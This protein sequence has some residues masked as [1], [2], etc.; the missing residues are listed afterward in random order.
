[1]A[2]YT[3]IETLK[4]LLAD[5]ALATKNT[6][7]D[8]TLLALYQ[9]RVDGL[10]PD[11]V[12]WYGAPDVVTSGSDAPTG[13]L[14][15]D[16]M[17]SRLALDIDGFEFT[18]SRFRDG[19]QTTPRKVRR[20][21]PG[22]ALFATPSDRVR[23]VLADPTDGVLLLDQNM[24]IVRTFPGL[25]PELTPITGAF[26]KDAEAACPATL[27]ATPTE[28]MIIACGEQHCVQILNYATGGLV[29]TIGTPGMAGFPDDVPVRLTDP[30]SISV[31]ELNSRLFIACRTGN[32]DTDTS[33]A[34]FVCEFDVTAPGAP[35]FVGYVVQGKGLYR[36]N[37][38]ECRRPSDVFFVP[39][40]VSPAVPARL[41]IANGLGD[42]A[43]LERAT[44]TDPWVPTLVIEAQGS[45]YV[46]G[47]D[48]VTVT[49]GFYAENALDVLTG[50]DT[51]TRV[52][53]AV[54]RLGL[55]EVFRAGSTS[56]ATPFG[57]HE[58]TYGVRRIENSMP[59]GT[60][61]R[62]HSTP[63]EPPLTFGVFTQATGVVADETTLP[64]EEVATSVLIVS[65]ADAGR[66][67]RVR[68]SIYST[69]NTVTFNPVTSGVAVQ[70][71]GWFLPPSA[72]F[73]P[74]F[75]TLEV[76]DPGSTTPVVA[77]GPW[78][79]V[80]RAGF[81]LPTQGPAM[82]RYQFRLRASLPR[83]APVRAYELGAVGVILRQ[84][85]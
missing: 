36:L 66:L 15:P 26:Y 33:D 32:P 46:L 43:A 25:V 56:T 37:N 53:V 64:G 65:D 52:S 67:Q 40:V 41:W 12:N 5:P 62:V 58:A 9:A 16:V 34:G 48:V 31:D 3:F 76:R 24:E 22:D 18:L 82:T 70:V 30:V 20:R 55:V 21:R 54:N 11:V 14:A 69:T 63:L 13:S 81:S 23:Y 7:L 2:V 50:S 57:K 60:P 28:H 83:T 35:V 44:L 6:S 84:A 71:V 4:R 45:G 85:W 80:P 72:D 10:T 8:P 73:P 29:A 27:G 1:M 42:V 39:A 79:E 47:P 17:R 74:D 77:A 68:L 49:N 38:S 51:H 61:L 75:L 59:F 19:L 78:R